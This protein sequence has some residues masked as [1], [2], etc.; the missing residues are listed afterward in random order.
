TSGPEAKE[1]FDDSDFR[2]PDDEEAQDAL[3]FFERLLEQD[4]QVHDQLTFTAFSDGRDFGAPEANASVRFSYELLVPDE[5]RVTVPAGAFEALKITQVVRFTANVD[6]YS[7]EEC[8]SWGETG[9]TTT[10]DGYD[11]GNSTTH[12][13]T[14]PQPSYPSSRPAHPYGCTQYETRQILRDLHVDET[15]A[16]TTVWLDADTFQPL[17]VVVDSPLDVGE[18]VREIIRAA[19]RDFWEG[20]PLRAFEEDQ[21]QLTATGTSE[22]V[23]REITGNARFSPYVGLFLASSLTGVMNGAL[24]GPFGGFPTPYPQ[25]GYGYAEP[26]YPSPTP[27]PDYHEMRSLSLYPEGPVSDGAVSY[28]VG[29]ASS[30]M[31]WYDVQVMVNGEPWKPVP[32]CPPA[33]DGAYAL[34]RG[35]ATI[36]GYEQVMAGDSIRLRGV[37]EGDSLMLVDVPSNTVMYAAT[38]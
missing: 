16:S 19:D 24:G 37:S 28:A 29:H 17:K 5:E 13:P 18:F 36:E 21:I 15:L 27:P 9:A 14:T 2:V 8:V 26:A 34:C 10:N 12:S 6:A 7:R 31:A 33:T 20:M 22:V 11:Y 32:E 30:R 4:L 38:I 1:S 23:A 35:D 25:P 3:R